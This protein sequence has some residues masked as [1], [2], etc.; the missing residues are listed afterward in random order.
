MPTW[1]TDKRD[2]SRNADWGL[3]QCG[4]ALSKSLKFQYPG[5]IL[6]KATNTDF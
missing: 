5:I 1:T 6:W 3:K 4:C 2:I